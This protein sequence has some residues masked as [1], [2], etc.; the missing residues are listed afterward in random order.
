MR[1]K[2]IKW[3]L[4]SI[5]CLIGFAM[6]ARRIMVL[7]GMPVAKP[8]FKFDPDAEFGIHQCITYIHIIAGAL[9]VSLGPFQFIPQ[10]RRSY[11]S[12]HRFAGWLFIAAAFVIGCSALALPFVIK[13]IGGF[14]EGAA[15]VFFGFIFLLYA[16]NAI[17]SVVKKDIDAHRE[18]MIRT[19]IL[20]LAVVTIRLINVLLFL[21]T[22]SSPQV[23]F[24]TAFWLGFSIHLLVAEWYIRYSRK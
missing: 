14:N 4:M 8:P 12:Y 16:F 21:F 13:L 3:V 20:G 5:F 9:F 7:N 6:V 23:F 15:T 18:W 22:R 19:F 1:K 10:I 2:S 24:G 17:R 11:L